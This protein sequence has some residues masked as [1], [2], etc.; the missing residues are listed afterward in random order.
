MIL[1]A[2]P[3][4]V[5]SGPATDP[6]NAAAANK[7]FTAADA[8]KAAGQAVKHVQVEGANHSFFD[9]KPDA[10]TK[11][12]FERYGVP[13]ATERQAFFNTVF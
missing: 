9:W 6:K 13:H 11:A 10:Q 12:T 5:F 2:F 8:L 7:D 4:A 1:T 3:S